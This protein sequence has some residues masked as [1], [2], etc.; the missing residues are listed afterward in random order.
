MLS[1]SACG[2]HTI[3]LSLTWFFPK[4]NPVQLLLGVLSQHCFQTQWLSGRLTVVLPS[5]WWSKTMQILPLPCC[6]SKCITY[7]FTQHQR[8]HSCGSQRITSYFLLHSPHLLIKLLSLLALPKEIFCKTQVFIL[9]SN[10]CRS[11]F[12][13][14]FFS[15]TLLCW[16]GFPNY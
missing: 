5:L 2:V 16:T 13:Q 3:S 11:P 14:V 7:K 9:G 1:Y 10:A 6:L 4:S 15:Q 8:L 12:G